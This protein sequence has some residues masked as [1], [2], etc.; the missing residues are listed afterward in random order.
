MI[1]TSSFTFDQV[2]D[3]GNNTDDIYTSVAQSVIQSALQGVNG[4]IFAY[5]QTS[6]GKTYSMSGIIKRAVDEIFDHIQNCEERQF[7]VQM[8]YME[9]YNEVIKDLMNPDSGTLK[10]HEDLRK[11]IY[12]GGLTE[13]EVHQEEVFQKLQDTE[14][15]RTVGKTAMN[16]ESSRSHS[17]LRI[18]SLCIDSELKEKDEEFGSKGLR[19]CL[20]L[21]DLAGS[22]RC[23][24]TKS[25]GIRLK[26]GGHI[27]KS[28]LTLGTVIRKLSEGSGSH[29]PYRDSKLTRILQ[30]ALGGISR[31]AILC[32]VTP[33]SMHTDE[34]L[35]TLKFA[36]RAKNIKN[37]IEINEIVDDATLIRRLKQENAQL[38]RRLNCVKIVEVRGR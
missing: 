20:N 24:Q 1:K 25:Q 14:R 32:C 3:D 31:T 23:S 37:K 7:R 15:N 30:T 5:G 36:S 38:K 35:S 10:V 26:E 21:V 2:F 9:I 4:T 16:S 8:S 28:L 17:I 11:G 6:S 27:N 34:T 33:A 13:I 12:V 19:A 29:I 18:V 22:E